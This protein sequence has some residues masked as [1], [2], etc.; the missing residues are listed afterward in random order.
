ML[1]LVQ[2]DPETMSRFPHQLSGGQ[3]QRI[4]IARALIIEPRLIICDEP[5]SALDV[6]VQAEII[7]LFI[8]LQKRLNL[9]FLFI[10][11]D[12]SVVEH[13]SDRV[14]VMYLGRIVEV[15]PSEELFK[16]PKHP[17]TECLLN[18]I[19]IAAVGRKEKKRT[20]IKGE[21]ADP[22]DIPTGC[23]FHPRCPYATDIC[24]QDVPQL[25]EV[26][27]S[28]FSACLRIEEI[29]LSGFEEIQLKR[30]A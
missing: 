22:T 19:P 4:G 26:K 13:I 28:H 27:D 16:N 15:A 25:S 8:D 21:I 20:I 18:S 17:Y 24:K 23:A 9:T 7:N 3:R 1:L 14:A 29:A 2:L 5:V 6:S 30:D 11:H 10:A 12:L